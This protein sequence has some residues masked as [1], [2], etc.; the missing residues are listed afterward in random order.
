MNNKYLIYSIGLILIVSLAYFLTTSV[1]NL[2]FVP[3]GAVLSEFETK[4]ENLNALLEKEIDH[5]EKLQKALKWCLVGRERIIEKRQHYDNK[6]IS[7]NKN[8]ENYQ[9]KEQ[10]YQIEINKISNI[11]YWDN[12]ENDF[13]SRLEKSNSFIDQ[14]KKDLEEIKQEITLNKS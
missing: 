5:N 8:S 2:G 7:L 10:S 9:K 6:I 4:L 14:A 3:D 12:C 1:K 11:P 13:Q